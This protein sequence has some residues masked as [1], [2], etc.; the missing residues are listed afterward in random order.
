MRGI[1]NGG[2]KNRILGRKE[3]LKMELREKL[4]KHFG[5]DLLFA[6]SFDSAIIG[7]SLGTTGGRVVY[8]V[9]KMVQ[10]LSKKQ[11]ITCEEAWEYLEY[12]TF[13][14]YVGERTPLYVTREAV[15]QIIEDVIHSKEELKAHHD[16]EDSFRLDIGG[17]G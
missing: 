1:E 16:K 8:D 5:D 3:S 2:T 7:V 6:D 17:E 15:K 9:E 13:G 14:A 11:G 12:N 4:S 10:V